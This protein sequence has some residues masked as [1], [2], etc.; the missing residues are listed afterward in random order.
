MEKTIKNFRNGGKD[1][2]RSHMVKIFKIQKWQKKFIKNGL[3]W[4]N[5][6]LDEMEVFNG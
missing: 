4:E 1:K 3:I 5:Q 2:V 6:K